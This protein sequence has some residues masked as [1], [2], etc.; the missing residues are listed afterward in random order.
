MPAAATA[1]A[2]VLML[3][4]GLLDPVSGLGQGDRP[5]QARPCLAA[6]SGTTV[7]TTV[8][9]NTS[10]YWANGF[11]FTKTVGVFANGASPMPGLMY[12]CGDAD[13]D[14]DWVGVFAER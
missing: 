8:L 3:G 1:V 7:L 11:E 5:Q 2:L 14:G 9:Q 10:T 12:C 4:Q 6:G 13:F